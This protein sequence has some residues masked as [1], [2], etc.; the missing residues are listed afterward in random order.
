M[1]SNIKKEMIK[2]INRITYKLNSLELILLS[3]PDYKQKEAIKTIKVAGKPS[4]NK[5]HNSSDVIW[6]KSLRKSYF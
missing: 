5:R 3:V 2:E 1:N 6:I 4:Y